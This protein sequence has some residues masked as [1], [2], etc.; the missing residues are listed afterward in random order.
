MWLAGYAITKRYRLK[1][2][3]GLMKDDVALAGETEESVFS[4]LDL[5]CSEPQQREIIEGKPVWKQ[6]C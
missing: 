2:S 3:V 5:P 6:A 4:A 1:C